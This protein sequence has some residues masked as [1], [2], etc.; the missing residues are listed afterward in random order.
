MSQPHRPP[1]IVVGVDD[2][3]G[4]AAALRWAVDEAHTWQAHLEV[5]HAWEPVSGTAARTAPAPAEAAAGGAVA[6]V[7]RLLDEIDT[8]GLD[9]TW[10]RADGPPAHALVAASTT[11]D[12]IGVG[13]RGMR[14]AEGLIRGSVREHCVTHAACSVAVVPNDERAA[15]ERAVAPPRVVVGTDGSAPS[16]VAMRWAFAEAQARGWTVRPLMAWSFLDQHRPGGD[17]RFLPTYKGS[18]A[19]AALDELVE[20]V[21]RDFDV[22]ADPVVRCDLPEA[23]LLDEVH[24]Q[25]LLVVGARGRG[26]LAGILL[27]SVS[28]R[29]VTEA[30]CPTIVVR[31]PNPGGPG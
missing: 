9:V 28:L 21:G 19:V 1:R 14:A 20:Q 4:A 2:T 22:A 6:M 31:S 12:L 10:T 5:I 23:A 25:D 13:T 24:P 11:A 15:R 27:G 8:T 17:D 16:L 29:C 3:R 26:A 30:P 7:D 18:E